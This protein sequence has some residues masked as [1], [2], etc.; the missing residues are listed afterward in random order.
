MALGASYYDST[1]KGAGTR[2][3][4]LNPSAI[5]LAL[6]QQARER[7]LG[8]QERN[9]T[10]REN[11]F[12][13]DAIKQ[14]NKQLDDLLSAISKP[15][16]IPTYAK[17]FQQQ[18]QDQ[19]N[20][21]AAAYNP[22]GTYDFEKKLTSDKLKHKVDQ[23]LARVEG[24]Y[25]TMGTMLDDFLSDSKGRYN[26]DALVSGLRESVYKVNENGERILRS[27]DELDE[28]LLNEVFGSADILNDAVVLKQWSDN[29]GTNLET[30]IKDNNPASD[31]STIQTIKSKFVRVDPT[32]GS[33]RDANGE[34]MW[35]FTP[36]LLEQALG[37][38]DMRKLIDKEFTR[39]QE[40]TPE[41][42]TKLQALE[43]IMREHVT[44]SDEKALRN[45]PKSGEGNDE[46]K[47]T[48]NQ[49]LE[50]ENAIEGDKM[51]RYLQQPFG[52]DGDRESVR[53][54]SQQ[55]LETF[56]RNGV[57]KGQELKDAFYLKAGESLTDKGYKTSSEGLEDKSSN[58]DRLIIVLPAEKGNLSNI[59]G[60]NKLEEINLS[61]A[62]S[63]QA[64]FNL[65]SGTNLFPNQDYVTFQNLLK[66]G[67]KQ[68][69]SNP[70]GGISINPVNN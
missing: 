59:G 53:P 27:P 32:T 61:D 11:Q 67:G 42:A 3:P 44:I 41:S 68:T 23:E 8:L 60:E 58:R 46:G 10:L 17:Y 29:F 50:V 45:N 25:K 12:G 40:A 1:N 66:K 5:G 64:F 57:Y 20:T 56:K 43:N 52:K 51:I 55:L 16:Q 7:Q 36:Q 28:S 37:D 34:V 69:P 22:D 15:T 62:S 48:F 38:S 24:Y 35:N 14:R 26:K 47:L 31:Q 39:L 13:L 2:L 4:G 49:S 21:A 9:Q 30:F 33:Y 65:I 70:Y 63:Y 54:E 6:S 19:F 18:A